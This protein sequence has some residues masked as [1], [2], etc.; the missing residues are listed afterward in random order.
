MSGTIF[1]NVEYLYGEMLKGKR[2]TLT[3]KAVE[4][5]AKFYNGAGGTN[6]GFSLV[7]NETQKKL[8]VTGITV[9]RQLFVATGTES[10]DGMIGKKITLY[11]VESKKSATG[12]AIRVAPAT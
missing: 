5:D 8:G 11:P 4:N 7:F 9:R 3:I 12:W 10:F 1:D 2:V 6:V